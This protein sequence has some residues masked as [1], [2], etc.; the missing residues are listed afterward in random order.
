VVKGQHHCAGGLENKPVTDPG[1]NSWDLQDYCRVH[2]LNSCLFLSSVLL[3]HFSPMLYFFDCFCI[4]VKYLHTAVRLVHNLCVFRRKPSTC[5]L[6]HEFGLF[7]IICRHI[8]IIYIY[9]YNIYIYYIDL[10]TK[11]LRFR[12]LKNLCWLG[13]IHLHHAQHGRWPLYFPRG[14]GYPLNTSVG[15]LCIT[16][17]A[18]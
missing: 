4:Y 10:G 11:L 7:Y 8:Y 6:L 16:R 2:A 14:C 1:D 17:E 3:L 13:S 9:I 5:V 12:C 18:I 15:Y